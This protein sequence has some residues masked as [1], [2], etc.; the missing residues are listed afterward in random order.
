MQTKS[1]YI[2]RLFWR[3]DIEYV[4]GTSQTVEVSR[5]DIKD[6]IMSAPDSLRA[7]K[8]VDV[9]NKYVVPYAYQL[10]KSWRK[11]AKNIKVTKDMRI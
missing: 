7:V 8:D 2:G 4:D 6:F 3:L 10:V 11:V 9:I 1:D 5:V